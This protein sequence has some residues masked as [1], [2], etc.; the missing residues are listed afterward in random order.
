[1]ERISKLD[2]AREIM[3]A[4]VETVGETRGAD[5]AG[6][7]EVSDD[8]Q[9]MHF[10][11]CWSN[12]VLE[13]LSGS[14]PIALAGEAALNA[15]NQGKTFVINHGPPG[16]ASTPPAWRS[17][18]TRASVSVPLL[19]EGRPVGASGRRAP[20]AAGRNRPCGGHRGPHLGRRQ[21]RQGGRGASPGQ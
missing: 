8:G 2:E 11:V 10:R 1:M 20:L 3:A 13:P 7:S 15:L 5:R 4:A 18:G 12:A 9:E 16:A 19:R 14:I 6:Y 17:M 21:A